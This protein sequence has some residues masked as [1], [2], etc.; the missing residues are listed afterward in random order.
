MPI[1]SLLPETH[2]TR[3][4]DAD[5]VLANATMPLR[6]LYFPLGFPVEIVTNSQAILMAADQS[7]GRF[8]KR[9]SH[10]PLTLRLGVTEDADD[11]SDLPPAP[12]CRIQGHLIS[13]IADPN[14]FVICDIDTGFSF[15]WVTQRVAEDTAYLRY[16]LLD[17][18]VLCMIASLRAAPLHAACVSPV[19]IGMLLCGDSGAGKSSLAFAGARAGWT[20]TCDDASYLLFDRADPTVVGNCHQF[21]L[22]DSG[23]QLF[24]ELE[25]RLI[26]P[27]ATGKPSIEIP[28]SDLPELNTAG[29]A[30]IRYIIFL[31]RSDVETPGLFPFAK[32]KALS[33]FQQ[34]L[35]KGSMS[36]AAHHENL[37][38]LLQVDIFELRYTSLDWAIERLNTLANKGS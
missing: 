7:W 26:T 14:N 38:N 5:P 16:H 34:S 20:F 12:V 24:P 22:R 23:V 11:S 8:Q 36:A 29:S 33:W 35:V 1:T 3:L 31:N 10:A 27:R 2:F 19:G 37:R 30:I 17:A 25:G 32:V 15:G 4:T 18:A 6:A 9:S 13:N 28:T 21:R